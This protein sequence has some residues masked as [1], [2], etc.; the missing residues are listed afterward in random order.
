MSTRRKVWGAAVGAVALAVL[1][2]TPAYASNPVLTHSWATGK[3]L[4]LTDQLCAKVDSGFNTS[5]TWATAEIRLNGVTQWSKTDY[6]NGDH[7]FVTTE[8]LSIPEDKANVLVGS[9]GTVYANPHCTSAKTDFF[10]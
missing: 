8:T 2:T 5:A 3:Y 7:Q 10:S 4:D 9:A 6:G 1:T